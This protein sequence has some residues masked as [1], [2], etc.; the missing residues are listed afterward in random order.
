M[1]NLNNIH[2]NLLTVV[3]GSLV[4]YQ[5][6]D[7]VKGS[8]RGFAFV[9][10]EESEDASEAIFNMDGAELLSRTIRVSL[11]QPNQMNKLH[12]TTRAAHNTAIWNSDEWFQQQQQQES[13][14]DDIDASTTKGDHA[15]LQ[16]Y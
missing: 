2:K 6:M 5:P 15:V 14:K 9:E 7:Y 8:H 3:A 11:A 1:Y 12:Q 10:M 4:K 16:E 13:Q